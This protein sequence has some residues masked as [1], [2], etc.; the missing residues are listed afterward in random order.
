[1]PSRWP[2]AT[3]MRLDLSGQ[4]LI[5]TIHAVFIQSLHNSYL[6][7]IQLKD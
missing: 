4:W 6:R 1:V 3:R 5:L 7:H 2:H